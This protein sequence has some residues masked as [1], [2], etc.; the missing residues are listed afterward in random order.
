MH[1]TRL[2]ITLAIA[3]ALAPVLPARAATF[4]SPLLTAIVGQQSQ[5][6]VSNVGTAPIN[7]SGT[8]Y[9]GSGSVVVPTSDGCAMLG[10]VLPANDTCILS[11][12]VGAVRCVVD[13]TSSKL[14]VV[15][16]VSDING[17]IA[18]EPATRK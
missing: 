13:A 16:M 6:R 14:R 4:S 15:L 7:V 3:A 11:F 17:I 1:S 5:C 2:T 9:D 10:G 18:T 8:F 12:G